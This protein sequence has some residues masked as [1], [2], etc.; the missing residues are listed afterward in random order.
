MALEGSVCMTANLADCSEFTIT[1][2]T[3]T[4]EVDNNPGG[5]GT[6][7]EERVDVA[8]YLCGYK[9]VKGADDTNITSVINNTD[10]ANVTDWTVANSEDGYY[11]F[12]LLIANIW[13]VTVQ[14]EPG[15]IVFYSQVWYKALT[16]HT[17]SAPSDI[18]TNWEIISDMCDEEDNTS[19]VSSTTYDMNFTCRVETC[20]A[21]VIEDSKAICIT[22]PDCD[23]SAI[24]LYIKLDVLFQAM[25][26]AMSRLNWQIADEITKTIIG[27]CKKTDCRVC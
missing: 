10:P 21:N 27:Y 16:T 22:C 26:I 3:G 12:K 14:Y 8:L 4:Y 9:Y 19:L 1:D 2:Q 24:K 17:G 5:Y 25:W 18:N 23:N 20:Y 11:Y 13:D 15:D 7:N 6:P